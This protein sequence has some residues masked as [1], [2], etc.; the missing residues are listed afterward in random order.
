MF[1]AQITD[2]HVVDRGQK[3]AGLL[4]TNGYVLRFL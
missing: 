4:D 1:I 3:L 2:L